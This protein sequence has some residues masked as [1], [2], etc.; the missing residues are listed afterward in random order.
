MSDNGIRTPRQGW[1]AI[2][3]EGPYSK[4]KSR[5]ENGD[6]RRGAYR[7]IEKSGRRARKESWVI[8]ERLSVFRE[9]SWQRPILSWKDWSQQIRHGIEVSSSF[10]KRWSQRRFPNIPGF[11][12]KFTKFVPS[13]IS[14]GDY[15]DIFEPKINFDLASWWRVLLDA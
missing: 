7:K 5:E 15:F 2:P 3:E 10:R 12:F 14:G 1:K 6:W 4:T 8:A 13:P 9:M 11:E